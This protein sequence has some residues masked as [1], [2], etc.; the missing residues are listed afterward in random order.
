MA[1]YSLTRRL[2]DA[3][4]FVQDCAVKLGFTT[5]HNIHVLT[6]PPVDR[7]AHLTTHANVVVIITATS[8]SSQ[9]VGHTPTV[10]FFVNSAVIFTTKSLARD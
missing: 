3:V 4:R 9:P 1:R 6:T 2:A 5:A 8:A 7:Q 10:V